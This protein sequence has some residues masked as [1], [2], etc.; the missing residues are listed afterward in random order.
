M[1]TDA[2]FPVSARLI[3]FTNLD[4]TLLD[5]KTYA[6]DAALPALQKLR[7]LDVPIILTSSKTVTEIKKLQ[8]DL[9]LSFPAIVENGAGVF[10]PDDHSGPE[11][12]QAAI[13]SCARGYKLIRAHLDVLEPE[14]RTYFRG[15][16]DLTTLQ[17]AQV[18][19]VSLK[20]AAL[21]R[22]R[23][24]S[25]PGIWLGTK[26]GLETFKV[27]L[28]QFGLV[29][30]Q[31]GRFLTIS[32]APGRHE[33]MKR[34]VACYKKQDVNRDETLVVMALGNA[35]NDREMLQDADI[36]VVIP[37][38]RGGE[39]NDVEVNANG[40]IWRAD[41][42]GPAGWNQTVLAAL[43][44]FPSYQKPLRRVPRMPRY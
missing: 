3:V 30:A 25:E 20:D 28:C 14:L 5:H 29:V 44:L 23:R 8:A 36:G 42:A 2:P 19:G 16:G 27:A 6:F 32:S 35:P 7:D 43:E 12:D 22:Q 21:A 41:H 11:I 1:K 26:E 4:G 38:A 37:G 9:G 15:F 10:V 13:N 24:W 31:G 18:T 34:L 17:V 40:V 39:M 33:L